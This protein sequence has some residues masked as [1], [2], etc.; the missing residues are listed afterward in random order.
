[1]QNAAGEGGACTHGGGEGRGGTA[2]KAPPRRS[3]KL[4]TST[5]TPRCHSRA[6]W[7]TNVQIVQCD[8]LFKSANSEHD[9]SRLIGLKVKLPDPC[10]QC[11]NHVAVITPGTK[12]HAHG[13]RC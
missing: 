2:R 11:G 7:R 1:M 12:P 3:S 10:R 5:T 6:T 13:L 9:T 8:D 4:L